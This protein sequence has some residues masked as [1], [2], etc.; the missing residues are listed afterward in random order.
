MR[1]GWAGLRM[2]LGLDLQNGPIGV[3]LNWWAQLRPSSFHWWV[4]PG[5]TNPAQMTT[6]VGWVKR[7]DTTSYRN[8]WSE[9]KTPL[10]LS[11]PLHTIMPPL[12][13]FATAATTLRS[14][15]THSLRTRGGGGGPSRW[16]TPGHEERPKGFAFNT[17][18]EMGGLGAS[19]LPHQLPHRLHSRSRPQREARS[20]DRDLGPSESPRTPRIGIVAARWFW[21]KTNKVSSIWCWCFRLGSYQ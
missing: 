20:H 18:A 21:L 7:S 13:P 1:S 10:S 14:R 9:H 11:L 15:L 8:N 6:L 17:I 4:G 5:P 19:V 16:T 3:H 2:V 12:K